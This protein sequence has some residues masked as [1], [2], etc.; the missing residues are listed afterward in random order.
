LKATLPDVSFNEKANFNLLSLSRL[1]KEGWTISRGDATI[2]EVRNAGG[3]TIR[4]DIVV[5]MPKGAVFA[6]RFVRDAELAMASTDPGTRMDVLTL[7]SATATK[8]QRG[9]WQR[10]SGGRSPEER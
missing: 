6:C 7:F 2:I 5:D 3:A 1:L 10:N 8:S 4:F 9:K